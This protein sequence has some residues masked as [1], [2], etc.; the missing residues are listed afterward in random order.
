MNGRV[1]FS[2]TSSCGSQ[3]YG[4]RMKHKSGLDQPCPIALSV[5]TEMF[6]NLCCPTESYEPPVAIDH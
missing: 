3:V 5:I 2:I 1:I 6:T 4:D